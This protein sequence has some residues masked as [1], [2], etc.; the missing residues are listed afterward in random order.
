M[1]RGVLGFDGAGGWVPDNFNFDN[2][3]YH[4]LVGSGNSQ[5][6]QVEGVYIKCR[7]WLFQRFDTHSLTHSLIARNKI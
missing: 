2:Q 7:F 4:E 1:R 3:Y 6:S 5:E